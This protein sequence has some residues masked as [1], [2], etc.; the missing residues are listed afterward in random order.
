MKSNHSMGHKQ[1]VINLVSNIVAF[2]TSFLISFV[3]TPY[4]IMHIGKEAYSFYPMSNNLIGYLTIV[5]LA[6]NSMVSRFISVNY[7][8]G[9]F[10]KAHSYYSSAFLANVLV[11]LLLLFPVTFFINNIENILNIPSN[12]IED[13]KVLF[14]LVFVSLLIDLV[15]SV[16]SVAT[17]VRN[18]MELRALSEIFKSIFRI[19]LFVILFSFFDISV[20][21][22]GIVAIGVSVLNL[23]V[24]YLFSKK[25]LPQ[26]SISWSSFSLLSIKTLLFSGFWN[27]VNALGSSLLLGMT[28]FLTNRYLGAEAGGN[29]SIALLLPAFITGIISIMSSVL[30]PKMTQVHATNNHDD[31]VKEVLFSQKILSVITTVPI[32][33]VI[34]FSDEFLKL[35]VP[36]EY[37]VL[38]SELSIILLIPLLIHGNMWC[39]YSVN[40]VIN[41]LKKLSLV[42]LFLG[43]LNVA[44]CIL[45]FQFFS[46][47]IYV[48]PLLSI[49]INIIY[50]L[51][52]VPVMTARNLNI[53]MFFYFPSILKSILFTFVFVC[54][55]LYLKSYLTIVNWFDLFVFSVLI[56]L[57]GLVIHCFIIMTRKEFIQSYRSLKRRRT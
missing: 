57:S 8:Q 18:R 37:S 45:W 55:S 43:A 27:V 7:N 17:F 24:Q 14:A 48:I 41:K 1:L 9:E 44:F 51:L 30:I 26:F 12:I 11:I 3:L 56:G 32:S 42:L 4:L 35:W 49:V 39:V 16:F 50:Y 13:V 40:I 10:N 52:F 38:L 20:V 47:N 19:V 28:L 25:L 21:F 46:I 34:I 23:L 53:N 31:L 54:S 2:S 36:S 6:L 33:I 22:I 29:L 5:T 15:S